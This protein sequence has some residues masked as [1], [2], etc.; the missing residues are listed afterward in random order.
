EGAPKLS[1][2][3][4]FQ[5]GPQKLTVP[6]VP[7]VEPTVLSPST[8]WPSNAKT[9]VD[10]LES[11]AGAYVSSPANEAVTGCGPSSPV[12][13]ARAQA[14]RPS[15]SVVPV[16]LWPP[17]EIETGAPTTGAKPSWVS[18]AATSTP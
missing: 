3:V 10:A 5:D 8:N 16:Q 18:T 17:T 12:N 15:S 9:I 6:P 4:L 14:A 1:T 7:A 11:S 2:F 13:G